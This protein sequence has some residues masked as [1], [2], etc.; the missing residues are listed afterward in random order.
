MS[1]PV[2]GLKYLHMLHLLVRVILKFVEVV[3]EVEYRTPHG[4]QCQ[5]HLHYGIRVHVCICA[6]AIAER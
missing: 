1:L 6:S 2:N 3:P 5:L 4:C